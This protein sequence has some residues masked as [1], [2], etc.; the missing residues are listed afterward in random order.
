M[1]YRTILIASAAL[2]AASPA[3]AQQTADPP[4]Q[5]P[6]VAAEPAADEPTASRRSREEVFVTGA[7]SVPVQRVDGARTFEQ[8]QRDREEGRCV[9]RAQESADPTEPNLGMPEAVCRDP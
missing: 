9:L 7:R 8:R 6:A 5:P 1:P 3:L 4:S 2:V